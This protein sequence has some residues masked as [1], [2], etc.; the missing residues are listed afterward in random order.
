MCS[1][2][3]CRDTDEQLSFRIRILHEEMKKYTAV[4]LLPEGEIDEPGQQKRSYKHHKHGVWCLLPFGV[5]QDLGSL[6][7]G[8]KN[9]IQFQVFTAGR[10]L[11]AACINHWSPAMTYLGR[12][13]LIH[14]LG[15]LCMLVYCCSPVMWIY[16]LMYSPAG[17]LFKKK[18]NSKLGQCPNLKN[19]HI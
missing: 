3:P 8:N 14:S 15:Y 9:R 6:W 2:S 4:P 12:S 1:E 16:M 17:Q 7:D 13:S 5:V 11:S 19:E 18:K 10:T